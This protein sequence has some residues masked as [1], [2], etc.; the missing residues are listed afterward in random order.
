MSISEFSSVQKYSC[1]AAN[2]SGILCGMDVFPACLLKSMIR[3]GK[4]KC[5]AE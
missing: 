4:H 2:F 5:F 3:I 1:M